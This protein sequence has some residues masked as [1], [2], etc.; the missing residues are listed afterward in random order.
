ML[1]GQNNTTTKK[2]KGEK[3]EYDVDDRR[4]RRS[5]SSR[6]RAKER[7]ER[8]GEGGRRG[9]KWVLDVALNSR[10][11][12]RHCCSISHLAHSSYPLPFFPSSCFLLLSFS[13]PEAAAAASSFPSFR[14][15]C[16]IIIIIIVIVSSIYYYFPLYFLLWHSLR[17]VFLSRSLLF[18]PALDTT[19]SRDILF[20][21]NMKARPAD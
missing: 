11:R 21:K 8:G 7:S 4:H 16:C 14:C 18:S 15:C 6:S 5:S 10:H 17:L 20:K 13:L 19:K 2:K 9:R 1:Q 3:K 12:R